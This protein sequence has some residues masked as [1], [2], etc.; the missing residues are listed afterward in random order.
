MLDAAVKLAEQGKAVYVVAA[1][2]QHAKQLEA[3]GGEKAAKLG[4]KF[5][6]AG[7]LSNL[8][9]NTL[10]LHGAHPN[11]KILVDHYAIES[12]FHCVLGMLHRFDT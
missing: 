12:R 8:D 1:T 7:M 6:A 4:I 3:T 9:W 10:T 2:M 11:C 5:E